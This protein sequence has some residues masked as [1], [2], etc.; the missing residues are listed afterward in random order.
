MYMGG[1]K[2]FTKN[3]YGI[4]IH[5]NGGSAIC[6]YY[7]DFKHGHNIVYYENCLMSVLYDK[8]KVS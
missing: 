5:D 6:S 8:N 7:N 1:M 4:I 3:G 2:S